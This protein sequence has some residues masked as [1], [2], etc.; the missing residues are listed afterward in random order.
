MLKIYSK[1]KCDKCEVLKDA[2]DQA[3]IV[4]NNVDITNNP[5]LRAVLIENVNEGTGFPI[6][7][8]DDKYSIAGDVVAILDRVNLQKERYDEVKK[9]DPNDNKVWAWGRNKHGETTDKW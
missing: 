4:Y 3:G 8:F 9:D 5:E 1:E 7:V 2:L 6:A